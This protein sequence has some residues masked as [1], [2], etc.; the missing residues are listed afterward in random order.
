MHR[1]IKFSTE[2][3][4]IERQRPIMQ[5]YG[6]LT[7]RDILVNRINK[8]PLQYRIVTM[9][10]YLHGKVYPMV[11]NRGQ[12]GQVVMVDSTHASSPGSIPSASRELIW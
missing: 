11:G 2:T 3:W 12:C 9:L 10:K 4:Y 6:G 1:D 5:T 8:N 7:L